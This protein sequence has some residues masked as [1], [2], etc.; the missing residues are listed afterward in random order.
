MGRPLSN[1]AK[2]AIF[3]AQTREAFIMLVT[4]N[5]ESFEQ[6]ARLSSNPS[7]LLIEAGVHGTVS[8]GEEYVF[9]PMTITLPM[10]DDTGI[11]RASIAIDNVDREVVAAARRANSPISVTIEIVLASDP[12]NVEVSVQ[13]FQ[14]ARVQYDALVLSGDISVEYFDLEPFPSGRFNPA[15]FPGIF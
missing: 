8:R 6:P 2:Q 7:E 1:A 13:D 14:L 11:A 4:L 5:H 15:D 10:Q 12:D 9:I 3:A